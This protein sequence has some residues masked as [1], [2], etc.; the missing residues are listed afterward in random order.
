[1]GILLMTGLLICVGISG[2]L[3][4]SGHDARS[5][6]DV[7]LKNIQDPNHCLLGY[8][9]FHECVDLTIYPLEGATEP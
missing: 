7:R 6:S 2:L 4:I 1:M 5:L 9:Q 3:G 8:L